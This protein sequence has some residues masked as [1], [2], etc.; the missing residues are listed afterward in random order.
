MKKII[1]SIISFVLVAVFSSCD[2]IVDREG[3][4]ALI[5]SADQIQA[6]VTP[7][8]FNGQNT[9]KVK[10]HCTS[11]V[12]CQWSDGVKTYISNDTAMTLFA[13]GDQTITLTGLAADGSKYAKDYSVKIDLMKY[14]VLPQYGYLCGTSSKTWT[15]AETK[16]FGNGHAYEWNPVNT[17]PEW[18]VL[19]PA[20]VTSQCV[21]K[22]LPKEGLGAKMTFTLR[23]TKLVKTDA[24]GVTLSSGKFAI[25]MTPD[26]HSWSTG[27]MT[28]TGANILCGYDFNGNMAPWSQYAITYLDETTLILG[29]KEH[30]PNTGFWYWVF[31]AM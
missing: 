16:C 4:G 27:T 19:G 30:A 20:D 15:W 28:L 6:T 29:A 31:K 23:G 21:E 18:W 14:P 1:Y 2:P 7:I 13:T 12:L 5:T 25:D 10:V 11:P 22:G 26:S 17:K 3:V 8:V 24:D 9:N